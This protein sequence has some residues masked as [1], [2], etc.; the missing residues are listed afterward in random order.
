MINK[1]VTCHEGIGGKGTIRSLTLIAA[2]A[3]GHVTDGTVEASTG[4]TDFTFHEDIG[5][6]VPEQGNGQPFLYDNIWDL[7]VDHVN[8]P[9]S[10]SV[11][12]MEFN[13]AVLDDNELGSAPEGAVGRCNFYIED[14]LTGQRQY[15]VTDALPTSVTGTYEQLSFSVQ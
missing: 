3:L 2:M 8:S 6:A 15:Y 7:T 5:C 1:N 10:G 14:N 13:N 12:F 4:A 9:I 11:V